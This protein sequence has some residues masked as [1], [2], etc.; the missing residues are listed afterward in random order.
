MR[1]LIAST[2]LIMACGCVAPP[3]DAE[4]VTVDLSNLDADAVD[5]GSALPPV[6]PCTVFR[7]DEVA[8]ALDRGPVEPANRVDDNECRFVW[9][10][11]TLSVSSM[12]N[13]SPD[14]FEEFR[15]MLGVEATPAEGLGDSA[16][17]WRDNR[18]YVRVKSRALTITVGQDQSNPVPTDRL[19]SALLTLG[20]IGA[21]R[22]RA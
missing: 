15:Q 7:P 17:F 1:Y 12:E 9:G 18:I 4:T 6:D 14:D 21:A 3:P 2:L 10:R 5:G 8:K 13:V 19:R 22:L 11:G 20:T 16:Y